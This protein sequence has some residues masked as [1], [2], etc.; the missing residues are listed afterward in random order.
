MQARRTLPRDSTVGHRDGSLSDPA[1]PC[2]FSQETLAAMDDAVTGR[3][4]SEPYQTTREAMAAFD[5]E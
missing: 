2:G 5:E 1:N 3:N 4:L